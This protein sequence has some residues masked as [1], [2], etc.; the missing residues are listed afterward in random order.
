M[1]INYHNKIILVLFFIEESFL[2]EMVKKSLFVLSSRIIYISPRNYVLIVS[3]WR[4]IDEANND[5][6]D[7]DGDHIY[8]DR[9]HIARK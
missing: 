4:R 3:N 7:S 6:L 2:L 5:L 9:R 8:Y 1:R